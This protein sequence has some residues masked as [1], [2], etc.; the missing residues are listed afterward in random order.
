MTILNRVWR[1]PYDLNILLLKTKKFSDFLRWG[2]RLFHSIMVDG[3]KEFL[4]NLCFV[5]TRGILCIFRIDY[6]KPLEGI[7][8]TEHLGFSFSK[9]QS[10][11][12]QRR[13]RRDSN[14]NSWQIFS[15]DVPLIPSVKARHAFYW[16]DSNFSLNEL[17]KAWS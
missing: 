8:L 15:F 10:S 14:P 9:R 2:S 3:K 5:L 17:L 1:S 12:H 16:I 4:K 13:S 11:T 7:K 6:N